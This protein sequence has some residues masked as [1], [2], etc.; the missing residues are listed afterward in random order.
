[1]KEVIYR[2]GWMTG[3]QRTA[4]HTE[5]QHT[6]NLSAHTTFLISCTRQVPVHI[7]PSGKGGKIKIKCVVK[8]EMTFSWW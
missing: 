1:M 6:Q 5:K 8:T 4:G 3:G 7:F 2:Y